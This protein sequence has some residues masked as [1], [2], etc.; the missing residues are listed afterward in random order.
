MIKGCPARATPYNPAFA[1][2]NSIL[3]ATAENMSIFV[4]GFLTLGWCHKELYEA[5]VKFGKILTSK[6]SLNFPDHKTKGYGY[7]CFEKAESVDAAIAEMNNKLVA[8]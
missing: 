6:A 4:S 5:F 3:E 8:G 2:V 1:K 7:I